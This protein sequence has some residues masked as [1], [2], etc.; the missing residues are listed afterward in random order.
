MGLS[1]LSLLVFYLPADSGEKI[2]LSVSLVTSQVLFL[3]LMMDNVPVTSLAVP[4]LGKIIIFNMILVFISII[5]TTIVLNIYY[6]KPTTHSQPKWVRRVRYSL[7]PKLLLMEAIPLG[8]NKSYRKSCCGERERES[9]NYSAQMDSESRLKEVSRL[10]SLSL[11]EI[12]C[13]IQG[14]SQDDGKYD[15]QRAYNSVCYVRNYMQ[16]LEET[17]AVIW[18]N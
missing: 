13:Q 6:R 16:R 3:L 17:N 11:Q 10:C 7:L 2:T 9:S 5:C 1:Y 12:N 4:L 18:L 14:S 15:I 8:G